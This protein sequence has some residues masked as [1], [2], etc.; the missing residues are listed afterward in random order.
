MSQTALI[1]KI[2]RELRYRTL[3]ELIGTTIPINGLESVE[4]D[5]ASR[6]DALFPENCRLIGPERKSMEGS[7]A[8]YGLLDLTYTAPSF[9][10]ESQ[11]E[12]GISLLKTLHF[13]IGPEE[14]EEIVR[15]MREL[16]ENFD[17]PTCLQN[18]NEDLEMKQTFLR[19]FL[20]TDHKAQG[21]EI[22]GILSP[23]FFPRVFTVKDACATNS[24][25]V[26]F[27]KHFY[28]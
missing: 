14:A 8:K 4:Q 17:D 19:L 1:K 28:F 23:G 6:L 11:Y 20:Q 27:H 12:S 2:S 26:W 22:L 9:L 15:E 7:T 25:Y 21:R 16:D 13:L 24:D 5:V 3:N 18:L 10:L